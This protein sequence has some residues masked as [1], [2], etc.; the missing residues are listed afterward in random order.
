MSGLAA[1]SEKSATNGMPRS[2]QNLMPP[3]LRTR[4][5]SAPCLARKPKRLASP[6]FSMRG[7]AR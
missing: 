5:P 1:L 2:E 3:A 7:V 6:G 4:M